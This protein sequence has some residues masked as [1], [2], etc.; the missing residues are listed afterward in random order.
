MSILSI[1]AVPERQWDLAGIG[2]SLLCVAHCVITPFLVGLLPTLELVE[3]ETHTALAFAILGIGLLAFVPGYR[4][5]RRWRVP[6]LGLVGFAMLS[7]G[8]FATEGLMGERLETVLTVLGGIALI[9]AHVRNAYFCRLC[10]VCGTEPCGGK[11]Q[12][13]AKV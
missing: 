13:V 1:T 7:T 6:A 3:R 8:A 5:H 11:A 2:A 4:H 12:V 9:S 10:R